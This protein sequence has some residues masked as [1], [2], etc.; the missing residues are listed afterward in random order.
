[1][2]YVGLLLFDL[3]SFSLCTGEVSVAEWDDSSLRLY[4]NLRVRVF[5]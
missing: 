3:N 5:V 1:M 2:F 4:G